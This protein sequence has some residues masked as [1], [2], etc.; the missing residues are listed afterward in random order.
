MQ[1]QFQ[2]IIEKFIRKRKSKQKERLE[3]DK[4]S[5]ECFTLSEEANKNKLTEIV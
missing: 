2:K 1:V 4:I 3:K 5:L